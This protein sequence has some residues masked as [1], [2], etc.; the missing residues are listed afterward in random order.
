MPEIQRDTTHGNSDTPQYQQVAACQ[1]EQ[2]KW[3]RER[4][5]N[6]PG[7]EERHGAYRGSLPP[8]QANHRGLS[9]DVAHCRRPKVNGQ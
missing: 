8:P 4:Y 7:G 5:R 2:T 1:Q 9:Q 6:R 3:M